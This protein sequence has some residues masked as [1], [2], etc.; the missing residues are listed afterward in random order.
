MSLAQDEAVAPGILR[1]GGVDAER[2]EEERRQDVGGREVAARVAHSGGV[3]HPQ[4][5]DADAPCPFSNARHDGR[6][7]MHA[8]YFMR[9]GE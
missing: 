6:I 1:P 3:H 9:H 4:A 5:G 8:F 2:M 7:N